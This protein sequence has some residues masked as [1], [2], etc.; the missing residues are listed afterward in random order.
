MILGLVESNI[1]LISSLVVPVISKYS[2]RNYFQL[3]AAEPRRQNTYAVNTCFG[4][5]T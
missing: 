2:R 3:G 4:R 1:I 5:L